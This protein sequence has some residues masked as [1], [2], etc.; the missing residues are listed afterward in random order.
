MTALQAGLHCVRGKWSPLVVFDR[1]VVV[2][3]AKSVDQA[4]EIAIG[5]GQHTLMNLGVIACGARASY[6]LDPLR[7]VGRGSCQLP[8]RER[9]LDVEFC[10]RR[11]VRQSRWRRRTKMRGL[12]FLIEV[13]LLG[14]EHVECFLRC[15]CSI[16]EAGKAHEVLLVWKL[17]AGVIG[18]LIAG[19]GAERRL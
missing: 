16:G 8:S 18:D 5:V 10:G 13:L 1:R 11:S 9:L 17:E 3:V 14:S 4:S 2:L 19:K 15:R 6:L 7:R 12:S